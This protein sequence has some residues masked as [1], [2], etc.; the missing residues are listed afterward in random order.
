MYLFQEIKEAVPIIEAARRYGLEL[1]RHNKALC[2]FHSDTPQPIL[3]GQLFQVLR[4][5]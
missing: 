1:D 4:L 3:Q 5:W 2:P